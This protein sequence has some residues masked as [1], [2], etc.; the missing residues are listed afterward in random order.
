VVTE[1]LRAC[2]E[3]GILEVRIVHGKGT[4]TLRRG[5][6]ALLDRLPEVAGYRQGGPG[7]GE[8]GAVIV[9]LRP[10]AD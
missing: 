4:G 3:Q 5:V 2:R 9:R 1:Y 6:L 10:L 7:G 8:W